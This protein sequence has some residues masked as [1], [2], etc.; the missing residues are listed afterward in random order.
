MSSIRWPPD[1]KRMKLFSR[2]FLG[3]VKLFG[4][5]PWWIIYSKSS[6]WAFF[7]AYLI[8]YRRGV[9][10]AN[11]GRT[12]A[13]NISIYKIYLNLMDLALESTK[14][15]TASL[16]EVDQRL[17]YKNPQVLEDLYS[18]GL[19][20][21]LVGGHLANWEMF[22]LS[23][24]NRFK[25]KTCAIY[26]KLNNSVF[27][28][29]IKKSRSRAGMEIMEMNECRDWLTQNNETPVLCS[30]IFD[31]SPRNPNHAYWTHFLGVETPI[32]PGVEKFAQ[33][34]NAAVVYA[35]IE[36]IGRGRYEMSFKLIEEDIHFIARGEVIEKCC[37]KLEED[38]VANPESWLWTHRRWKHKRPS[39]VKLHERNITKFE[40]W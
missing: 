40:G 39:N 14:L 23:M 19:N 11:L 38:I 34:M 7:L 18:R 8:R 5:L 1:F 26:K 35:S 17:R 24:P 15:F 22:A 4:R 16:K 6:V 25:H 13:G 36:R 12:G 27:D 30:L 20:V 37:A 10:L 31:Q 32:Y 3:F 2:I 9:V 29:A 33:R 28:E 21:V